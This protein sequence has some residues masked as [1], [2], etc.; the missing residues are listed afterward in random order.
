MFAL[1]FD[2]DEDEAQRKN[3]KKIVRVANGM[4]DTFLRGTGIYGAIASTA[5][6]T[7]I[8]ILQEE[9]KGYN[10]DVA[11]IMIELLN[12]SPP[13]G[14]K[15]RKIVATPYRT[16]SYQKRAIK[17]LSPYDLN[18]PAYEIGASVVEGVFNIPTMRLLNKYKNIT[19]VLNSKNTATQRIFLGL[20]WDRYGLNVEKPQYLIDA[21]KKRRG[22][23]GGTITF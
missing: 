23:G 1:A 17:N 14:S 21:R 12:L 16:Y 11:G 9:E 3:Q 2:D 13:L 15:M 5:K 4:A 7:I 20:G 22:Q 10:K 19:E 6:N 8:K 18:N